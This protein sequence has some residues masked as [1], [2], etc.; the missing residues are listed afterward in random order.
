MERAKIWLLSAA[1]LCGLATQVWAQGNE[2]RIPVEEYRDKMAAGWIG[3]MA[4]VGWGAPTEFRYKGLIIPEENVPVWKPETVNQFRQ[5]DI[6]VEMTFLRSM[7]LH[8]FDVSIRQAGIDFANSGYRLWHAN[9]FGRTNLRDGI[10]PPDSGHPQFNAHAD[11]IDYQIE[12]DYSGL[13]A[14]G[15]PNV[16]I[17]LGEKFGRLMNYGDGLYGGQFVAGMYAEAFFE[18]D[19][20]KIV[21]AGLKCIPAG[22]Q[23]AETVRDVLRWHKEEPKDWQTV[24]RRIDEKYHQ[25]ADHRRFTCRTEGG[26]NIDAKINGAYIVMG[27]LYGERNLDDTI[28]ISMRCGQ[29]SDCNPSNAGGILFTTLGMKKLPP[30]FTSALDTSIEFSHTEY[31]FDALLDVCEKLARKAV[32]RSGGRIE[33]DAKGR[34]TFVIPVMAAKPSA[35]EQ[36]W[37]PGPIANSRFTGAE[38]KEINPPP[39]PPRRKAGT[40][41]PI[42]I[43]KA[44]AAFAPGWTVR[45]CGNAMQPGLRKEW[46][47]RKNVLVT[48]PL[49]GKTPC[50]LSR[51]VPIP[52]GKKTS[53]ELSVRDSNNGDWELVVRLGEKQIFQKLIGDS[54]WQDIS[55]DLSEY[56]GKTIDIELLNQANG[57]KNEAAFW[58]K[59]SV[60]TRIENAWQPFGYKEVGGILGERLALWRNER[61]WH[62]ADDG[63]LL[64]G[65]E[66]R[67]GIHAWQG[68][69]VGKW[70]DAA[71]LAHQQTGDKK[72]AKELH[73]TVER[74]IATQEPNGYM[75]TYGSGYRFTEKPENV[76]ITDIVD[77]VS[78][79][80]PKGK[81][82]KVKPKGG[83][84]TWTFRY[85]IYGLLTY[86]RFYP[87][88]RVVEACEKM[89]DLLIEVY[90]EGKY[91][92]TK[93]GTRKGISATTL[94]ESIVMLYERTQ[95][96]RFLKFAEH[97]V[98][99]SESNDALRLMGA[100][101]NEE[102][103]SGPGEGK[104][105]Q[106][107]ANLLGYARLYKCTGNEKYLTT[108]INGWRNIKERHLMATGGPWSRKM[109]Y[110]GN[111]ECFARA[112]DFDPAKVK[113]ETC[114]TTTWIQLCL[115]LFE[116]TGHA[117]YAQEAEKAAFNTLL[118]AQ[119]QEGIDWCY[120]V[121]ANQ[122]TRPYESRMSCCASSGPRAFEMFS[123]YLVG[124]M[125]GGVALSSL[126]PGSVS[127]PSKLGNAHITITGDFPFKPEMKIRFDAANGKTFPISFRTPADARLESVLVNGKSI[128]PHSTDRGFHQITRQWKKGDTVAVEFEYLLNSQIK[129]GQ[130]KKKWIAFSYGPWALAQEIQDGST[131]DEP[132]KGLDAQS[133]DPVTLLVPQEGPGAIPSI[134]IKGTEITLIPYYLAGSKTTGSRTYFDL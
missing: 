50:V 121:T 51:S 80:K 84:D 46:G 58:S 82:P 1:I 88:E 13:I 122:A 37:E 25:D 38:M 120:F 7:E 48:H 31:D 86:E 109:S 93:Y 61:L 43:S 90:G 54:K 130:D 127:L 21:E 126:A 119:Y 95:E 15:M 47:G 98:A 59:I 35:L 118:A 105:Y 106:L 114:S 36:C 65:F 62:M 71:T 89:A 108:A 57:W 63:Y 81:Q 103:V 17:A 44:V 100:M 92:L 83:W 45:D 101:L 3:Q 75:G 111:G 132:F 91:D 6:Y 20:R 102:D 22:S 14:P 49:N 78:T 96:D 72:L 30:R 28:V 123:R 74:L 131:L 116:L 2:R 16:G 68:E 60:E 125:D 12:A 113:V 39:D 73:E 27:L 56:A 24:W 32:E 133:K 29:D 87:N 99:S 69:H 64:S 41:Q 112:E 34:E 77:D 94:L 104:A 124:E 66:S 19:P 76:A 26:F 134:R 42:D 128:V 11:D 33:K 79:P 53:L 9:V 18:D 5:D 67:P 4:G 55:I 115:H 85:N 8:G 129:S 10:A 23:Y 107:M 117:D 40:A 110:N 97:I 52:S 70:L